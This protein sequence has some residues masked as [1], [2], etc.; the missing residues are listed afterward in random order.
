MEKYFVEI[1]KLKFLIY[2]IAVTLIAAFGV[3]TACSD[4]EETSKESIDRIVA[5]TGIELNTNNLEVMAR[6]KAQLTYILSPNNATN[7]DVTWTSSNNGV[8]SVVYG[9]VTGV[10]AGTATI[11]ATT[12][13][14]GKTATCVVT[15]IPF[16]ANAVTGVSLDPLDPIPTAKKVKLVAK[17]IPANAD[18]KNVTWASS[19]TGVAS[20]SGDGLLEAKSAGTAT[21]TVTTEEGGKT[22]TCNVTVTDDFLIDDFEWHNV[23]DILPSGGWNDS[24]VGKVEVVLAPQDKVA[25][26]PAGIANVGPGQIAFIYGNLVNASYGNIGSNRV[27]PKFEIQLP[28]GK[29]LGN[30]TSL[31]FDAYVYRGKDTDPNLGDPPLG[32]AESGCGWFGSGVHIR[33]NDVQ[34]GSTNLRT[35]GSLCFDPTGADQSAWQI[36]TWARGIKVDLSELGADNLAKVTGL[37]TFTLVFGTESGYAVY[38][39]DNVILKK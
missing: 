38:C 19:N 35:R 8:A 14:G 12:N 31:T 3:T 23:G 6:S 1:K 15:V 4:E 27:A 18:N 37:N 13:D 25:S 28:A 22:A 9:E 17:I 24:P 11:T 7:R 10:A 34:G 29:N 36:R 5:V 30:Y 20:I 39:I 32:D 33:I 16:I 2:M 26:D 21:I